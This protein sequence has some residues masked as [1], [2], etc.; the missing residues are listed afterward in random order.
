MQLAS[1]GSSSGRRRRLLQAA[2]DSVEVF[3]DI[4]K[5]PSGQ[6]A[7]VT[8]TLDSASTASALVAA[9]TAAG[10]LDLGSEDGIGRGRVRVKLSLDCCSIAGQC[11]HGDCLCYGALRPLVRISRRNRWDEGW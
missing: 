5:V 9:L 3:Y 6:S 7:S 2:S 11:V 8:S 10:A 4:A 1:N